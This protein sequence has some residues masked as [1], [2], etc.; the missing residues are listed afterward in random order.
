[1][2]GRKFV[3]RHIYSKNSLDDG[4]TQV[5][6]AQGANFSK[7]V[8]CVTYHHCDGDEFKIG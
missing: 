5:E 4:K 3:S 7:I 2:I 8:N 6:Y 1:M